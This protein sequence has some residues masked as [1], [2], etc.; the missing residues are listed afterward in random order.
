[1]KILSLKIGC[2]DTEIIV[3]KNKLISPVFIV[4]YLDEHTVDYDVHLHD[5]DLSSL[6][7][8]TIP[9]ERMSFPALHLSS[10]DLLRQ[11]SPTIFVSEAFLKREQTRLS[12]DYDDMP[13][14]HDEFREGIVDDD[15]MEDV[16]TDDDDIFI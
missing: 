2:L 10:I 14:S 15:A 13:P 12:L 16:D 1:M 8:I 7:Y 4:P 11:L 6:T 5:I 3:A 9:L